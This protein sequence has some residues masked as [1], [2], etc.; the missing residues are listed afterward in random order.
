MPGNPLEEFVPSLP[1]TYSIKIKSHYL[2]ERERAISIPSEW[3]NELIIDGATPEDIKARLEH[4]LAE[5]VKASISQWNTMWYFCS[6]LRRG[7]ITSDA[8]RLDDVDKPFLD[9]C[10]NFYSKIQELGLCFICEDYRIES[11]NHDNVVW[12][13]EPGSSDNDCYYAYS[14]DCRWGECSYGEGYIDVN[15]G[16]YIYCSSNEAYYESDEVAHQCGIYWRE[17]CEEYVHENIGRCCDRNPNYSCSTFDNSYIQSESTSYLKT[18]SMNYTYGV[19]IESCTRR[20]MEDGNTDYLNLKTM[21]DGS[22]EGLEYVTGVLEG[23][24]GVQQLKD[25]CRVLR[26]EDVRVD[27]SCGVHIHIGNT[28]FNRRF[29]IMLLKL[30]KQIEK[31]VYSI[32]PESRK[33]NTYC[34]LLPDNISAMNFH[35]YR[36]TL[37]NFTQGTPISKDYNKKKNHPGG[38]YNS[39]RYYWVNLTNCSARTGPETVEFRPHGATIDFNKI[40]NWLLICMSIVKFAE[41]YQR[42]I[43]TSDFSSKGPITLREVL[44]CSLNKRLYDS[45]WKYCKERASSFGNTITTQ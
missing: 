19:E 12:V 29:S 33:T 35:N 15:V 2:E 22:I 38:H 37:G 13:G 21:E 26:E 5:H 18:S 44:D 30:C 10:F 4:N 23:D 1:A 11:I 24:V 7:N 9:L 16:D 32:M 39:Q 28:I 34:K 3:F 27:R 14:D 40:Y 41:N 42:R 36:K 31:D 45:V 6:E 17:C 43:I 8:R 25:I 20:S